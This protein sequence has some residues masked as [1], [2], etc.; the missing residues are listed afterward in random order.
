MMVKKRKMND[1]SR[2][3]NNFSNDLIDKYKASMM[4]ESEKL[5]CSNCGEKGTINV[6]SNLLKCSNCGKE[7]SI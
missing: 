6:E 3:L 7:Y 2:S 1:L 5:K 4:K